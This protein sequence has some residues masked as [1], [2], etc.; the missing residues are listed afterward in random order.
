MEHLPPVLYVNLDRATQRRTNLEKELARTLPSD[1]R[2]V[3]IPG[4]DGSKIRDSGSPLPYVGMFAQFTLKHRGRRTSRC[5]PPTTSVP[6][7]TH[8]WRT[9]DVDFL[10]FTREPT[11]AVHWGATSAT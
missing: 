10:V 9:G 8:R 1:A 11:G 7:H 2:I 3:R 4:V 6:P 5:H